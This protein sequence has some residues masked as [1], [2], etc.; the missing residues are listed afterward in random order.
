MNS[1]ELKQF[2]NQIVIEHL[3]KIIKCELSMNY[4]WMFLNKKWAIHEICELST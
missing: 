3:W 2:M 1:H 4:P